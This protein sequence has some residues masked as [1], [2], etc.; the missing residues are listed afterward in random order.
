M[1]S[2]P[3]NYEDCGGI[4]TLMAYSNVAV[5]PNLCSP[6]SRMCST[7]CKIVQSKIYVLWT[8]TQINSAL[9]TIFNFILINSAANML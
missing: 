1:R 8:F 3:C 7:S 5:Q 6:K 2:N 4:K 9:V